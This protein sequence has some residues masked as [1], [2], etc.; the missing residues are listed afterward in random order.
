MTFEIVWHNPAPSR[1]MQSRLEL[2]VVDEFGALY[3]VIGTD[4]ST[5]FEL[6]LGG[7]A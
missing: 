4:R 6:I 1:A 2:I 7:A 3:A 5:T